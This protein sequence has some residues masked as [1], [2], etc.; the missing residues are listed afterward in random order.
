MAVGGVR[1]AELDAVTIDGYRT[2]LRLR[3]P[4]PALSAAL[5]EHGV[6]ADAD[7]VRRAFA[8]EVEYYERHKESARDEETLAVL[9]RDCANAFLRAVPC[10]L[11]AEEFV[12][13]FVASLVFEPEPGALAAVRALAARGLSLA[14]VANWDV[15]LREHLVR[16]GLAAPFAAVV[17]S[18][19][20]G[21]SKP[22]PG[23]FRVALERLGVVPERALHVGDDENDERGAAAAGLRFAP[24]PLASAVAALV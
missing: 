11:A 17:I 18:A 23:P 7:T 19:E 16:H 2:L 8:S 15:S 3:D 24:A 20:V 21:A 12:D 22:D 5:A 4:V 13:A 14:V 1:L 10:E 9:R 6:E